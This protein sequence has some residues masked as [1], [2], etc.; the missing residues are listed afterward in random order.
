MNNGGPHD[1]LFNILNNLDLD[2]DTIFNFSCN[3]KLN[4]H[5]S[6][7]SL[8]VKDKYKKYNEITNDEKKIILLDLF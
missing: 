2:L 4:K 5:K 3:A 8:Y 7:C 1:I 6:Q